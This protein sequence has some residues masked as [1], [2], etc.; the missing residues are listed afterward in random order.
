[1]RPVDQ[2]E[3]QPVPT[4]LESVSTQGSQTGH[5]PKAP[6]F[7]QLDGLRGLAAVGVVGY[8]Y[9]VV[10]AAHKLPLLGRALNLLE[11]SPLSLDVFFILSGFLIGG[12]LLRTR[13][14]PHYY[15]TF[16]QRRFSRIFP[17]YY[18]WIALFSVLYFVGQ[19]WGL[20]PPQGYSGAFYLASFA[21]FFQSFFPAIIKSTYIVMPTWTLA[22]EEYFYLLI[23]VCVRRLSSRRLAQLLL[24]VIVLAPLFRG[25]LFKYIGHRNDWADIA[26]RIWPPCR[27]DALAMGVL[28][29]MAWS[30]PEIRA[31]LHNH[32]PLFRWGIFAC[33]GLAILF[34]WM[35]EASFH[36]SRVL[37]VSLGRSAVEL[38]C[39]CFIVFLICRPQAAFSRFLTSSIMR[40][41]GKISY[42]LY[43]IH[44]G[45]YWMIFRFVLHVR[46]GEHL[47]LDVVVAP[48]AFLISFAIAELSWNYLELPIL[49]RARGVRGQLLP[50]AI[51]GHE[52]QPA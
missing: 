26:T 38:S 25:V 17:L 32:L 44:W 3:V 50:P 15:K 19:G 51:P 14:A 11:M 13:N 47:W 16:Y 8:H 52:P 49:L 46:F 36:H 35:A 10:G 27:A 39:F 28:L 31:W 21:C 42:C 20:L 5:A 48:F 41:F 6:R 37:N 24:T 2:A 30:V 22:V 34:A 33:S 12:M 7:P 45:V 18:A 1:M 43:L 29:A 9:T 4:S 23:P 40:E